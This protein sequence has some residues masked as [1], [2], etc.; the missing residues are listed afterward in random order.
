MPVR[1]A[2]RTTRVVPLLV[3]VL[4]VVAVAGAGVAT[5]RLFVRP[6]TDRPGRA[7]AI[8]VLAGG[9]GER[10][11]RARR[12]LDGDPTAT[13]VI[14]NGY[15]ARWH[16]ANRLCARPQAFRVLCFTP[17]PNTTRGEAETV[18]R[19]ATEHGWRRV[20]VVTSTYHVTRAAL[21]VRRCFHGELAMVAATPRASS[22]PSWVGRIAH[23]WGGLLEAGL[24]TGC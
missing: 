3:A 16:E 7:D 8:V 17:T 10:L 22:F 11:D 23:E 6:H 14:S 18:A 21:L 1:R 20:A 15:D 5:V 2:V 13:L 24:R 19:L 12:V 9:N 4:V